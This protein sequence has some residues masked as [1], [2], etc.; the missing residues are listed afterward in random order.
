MTIQEAA[1]RWGVK[2]KTILGYILKGYIYG[3]SVVNNEIQ[4]PEIPKPY[5]VR[6]PKTINQQDNYILNAMNKEYYVNAKI[7]DINQEKFRERL[8]A[9]MSAKK[10]SPK[11]PDEISFLTNLEFILA[12][13][14]SK[15]ISVTVS[16]AI[17]LSPTIEIKVADQIGLINGKVG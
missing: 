7:M 10:I 9:L 4:L 13:L 3:L 12:S 11:N 16:P 8:V 2:E 17:E 6:K 15:N 1:K 5:V 14:E